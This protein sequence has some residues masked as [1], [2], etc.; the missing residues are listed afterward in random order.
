MFVP[1]TLKQTMVE[2]LSFVKR[3]PGGV[4]QLSVPL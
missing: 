1:L 2:R 3:C 4:S